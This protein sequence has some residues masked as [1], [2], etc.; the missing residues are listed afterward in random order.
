MGCYWW[1]FQPLNSFGG[2]ELSFKRR[3][4]DLKHFSQDPSEIQIFSC[5]RGW[6][7]NP[8]TR[9][10]YR[11]VRK[12]PQLPSSASQIAILFLVST[13]LHSVLFFFFFSLQVKLRIM[14]NVAIIQSAL[15]CVQDD[16]CCEM[17]LC[18]IVH[19]Y[20]HRWVV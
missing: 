3:N 4:S 9:D 7:C 19:F 1:E 6:G 8:P 10:L 16:F 17:C 13:W 15:G 2:G 14:P 5:D 20:Q 12:A 18:F 11:K